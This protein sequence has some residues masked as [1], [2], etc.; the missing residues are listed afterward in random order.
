MAAL[1]ADVTTFAL[2]GK[3]PQ[4]TVP[5]RAAAA[6]VFYRGA[7]TFDSATGIIVTA[8][9]DAIIARGIVAERTT[10]TAAN[11]RVT[12]YIYGHMLV[13]NANF[14]IA[15]E[16]LKFRGTTAGVD[17]PA[18][19]VITA[20]GVGIAGA[21]GVLTTVETTAVDGWLFVSPTVID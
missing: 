6:D 8:P 21:V 5:L 7:V 9:G 14:T 15:N 1:T 16:G 10:T 12:C 20:P 17:D 19:L 4:I 11:D 3:V 13:P 18:T 2:D